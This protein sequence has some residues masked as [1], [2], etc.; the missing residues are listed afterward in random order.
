MGNYAYLAS[1]AI[2][3]QSVMDALADAETLQA[4][5]SGL[6]CGLYV[7]AA[8]QLGYDCRG[9]LWGGAEAVPVWYA[10]SAAR[11]AFRACPGLRED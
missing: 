5:V 10:I 2:M 6:S 8:A 4:N 1:E 11:A 9:S 7:L 3:T